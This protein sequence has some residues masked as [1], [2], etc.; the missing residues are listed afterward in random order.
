MLRLSGEAD[1][2]VPALSLPDPKGLPSL[3]RFTQYEAVALFIERARAVK[4]TFSVTDENA[5]AVAELCHR[6]DGLPL[7]IELAAAH[8]RVLPP[9]RM[10]AE[11]SHR[12]N[13]LVGGARD[14]PARQKTLRGAIDWSHDL[15]TSAE[16][17]LFRRLAVFA[18]GSTLDAIEAVSNSEV[19]LDVLGT[20]E[21]LV[22][23]SLLKQTDAHGEP[24]F[25][26]LETIR[27]YAGEKLLAA[28]EEERERERHR[29]YYLALAEEA[30]AKLMGAEQTEWLQH[31]KTSMRTCG[32]LSTGASWWR[33]REEVF[34]FAGRFN[35][36][37]RR[38]DILR[39]AGGGVRGSS[40]GRQARRERLSARRRSMRRA[41][42]PRCRPTIPPPVRS[43][44]RAWRSG[45]DWATGVASPAR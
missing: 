12:L 45:V 17:R 21:S 36:S 5:P 32:R 44:R 41:Y 26:M 30:Q 42:W 24:R 40:E 35:G 6:L 27:E 19:D 25:A 39:R 11:L 33:K 23:K 2:P 28:G 37:G 31:W 16:Q 3:E 9:Q 38:A 13:F 10:L 34:D 1:Y 29:E 15:L 43:T 22:G 7:A 14:L 4:P 8:T 20:I 18:G